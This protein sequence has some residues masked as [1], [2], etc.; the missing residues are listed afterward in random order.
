MVEAPRW[1]EAQL[2]EEAAKAKSLFRKERLLE[3]LE[4]WKKVVEEGRTLYAELFRLQHLGDPRQLTHAQLAEL[5]EGGFGDA[6]RYMTGPPI[7]KDDLAVLAD[8]TL[9]PAKLRKDPEAATRVLDIIANALD[10]LRFPWIVQGRVPTPSELAVAE[11]SSAVLI[12]A[13]RLSTQRRGEGK[14]QQE[15]AVKKML[16]RIGLKQVKSRA[17]KTVSDAPE[18]GTFCGEA[19]VGSRKA[20][21]PTM[22][23]DGRLMAIECKVSNSAT[24]SVKRLNNDAGAKAAAWREEFGKNNIVPTAVLS[25]VFKVVNLLQAQDQGLTLFWSHDLEKLQQFA[26]ATK[27]G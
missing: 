26:M 25:G 27:R 7:S 12:A 4:R 16:A 20:D 2:A 17:I 6:L 22:L 14:E 5:L 11:M 24:N 9:A 23:F 10:P 19:M 18:R 15:A 21:I 8:C 13:Q 3:P 1:S